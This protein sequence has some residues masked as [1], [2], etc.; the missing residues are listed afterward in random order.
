MIASPKL[1]QMLDTLPNRFRGPGGVAGIVKD[2]A[3]VASRAWGYADL[4]SRR[5]MTTGTRLPICSISK[6]FTC[7]ALLDQFGT[8]EALDPGLSELLPNFT[9]KLPSVEQ[10]CHNQSGL[11]DY[12]ALTILQGAKAEQTF[13]RDDAFKM[14]DRIKTT[15]FEPGTSYSYCNGN[16]RLLGELIERTSGRALGGLLSEVIF[17][18]AG[19]QT[20]AL[21]PDSRVPADGVVGYEGNEQAGFMPADN[22]IYWFGDAGISASLEDMLAYENW[23]DANRDNPDNPYQRIAT[24]PSFKDGTP[25]HYGYGLAHMELAGRKVTGH[26]GALRGFRAFRLYCKQER[27]SVVVILNHEGSAFGA[28]EA[29]FHAAVGHEAPAPQAMPEGWDGQWLCPETKLLTALESGKTDAHL[30][31]A[32][33]GDTLFAAADGTLKGG[34]CTLRK[35]NDRVIMERKDENLVTTLTELATTPFTP[36]AEFAGRYYCDELDAT[37]NIVA[38]DGGLYAVCEGVL[39][40]GIMERVHPVGPDTWIFVTRRSMDAPAPGEWTIIASRTE[41]GKIGN[42]TVG[43]WLARKLV[44]RRL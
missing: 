11:R 38:Q 8:T 43:C 37:L 27:L 16:F 33:G 28:A 17:G 23:I 21:L 25:A 24:P 2:G 20:A 31:F 6:Q 35:E 18:P 12:W 10:L 32:T 14:F 5:K 19:M 1:E 39:G 9:E 36:N 4:A 26:A 13:A 42:L 30:H 40:T 22:G 3:V 7:A 41:D 44:Y 29:L 34:T 15:H